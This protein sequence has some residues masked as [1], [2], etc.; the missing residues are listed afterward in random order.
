MIFLIEE[1]EYSNRVRFS[2]KMDDCLSLLLYKRMRGKY[3]WDCRVQNTNETSVI[4][5]QDS[6]LIQDKNNHVNLRPA[7]LVVFYLRKTWVPENHRMVIPINSKVQCLSLAA[8]KRRTGV[9]W[10]LLVSTKHATIHAGFQIY[11]S[12]WCFFWKFRWEWV[13]G[14]HTLHIRRSI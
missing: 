6:V 1:F 10:L 2:H 11:G 3:G 13:V 7:L 8:K 12:L 14:L 9:R 5:I 4:R